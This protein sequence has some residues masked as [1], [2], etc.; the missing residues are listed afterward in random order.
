M[1][2]VVSFDRLLIGIAVLSSLGI[3]YAI[4]AKP[5]MPATIALLQNARAELA[6]AAP[7]KGGHRERALALVDQAIVEVREGMSLTTTR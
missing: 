5:R 4:G 2:R 7:K 3:V 1:S 6:A